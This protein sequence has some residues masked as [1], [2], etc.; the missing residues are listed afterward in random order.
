MGLAILWTKSL[1]Y[2]M[3]NKII[4]SYLNDFKQTPPKNEGMREARKQ[5]SVR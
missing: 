4:I 5:E 1:I 3:D 2:L